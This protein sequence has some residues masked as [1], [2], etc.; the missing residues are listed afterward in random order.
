MFINTNV[1]PAP[2]LLAQLRKIQFKTNIFSLKYLH[3]GLSYS[4]AENI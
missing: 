1:H 2:E 3:G 4:D